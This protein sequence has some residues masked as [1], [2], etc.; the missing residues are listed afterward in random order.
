M[1]RWL[2]IPAALAASLAVHA[3]GLSLGVTPDAVQ[4]EGGANVAEVRIGSAFRD[5]VQGT[6]NAASTPVAPSPT[7]QPTTSVR[8]HHPVTPSARPVTAVASAP[9]THQPRSD[10]AT[11]TAAMTVTTPT[12]PV[13][14]AIDP[15]HST[16]IA[17]SQSHATPSPAVTAAQPPVAETIVASEPQATTPLI[18]ARPPSKPAVPEDF[19]PT[20]PRVQAARGNAD[21]DRRAGSARGQEQA[22]APAAPAAQARAQATSSGAAAAANYA[23]QVMARLARQRVPRLSERGRATVG[24]SI[25]SSGGLGSVSLIAS[26]GS[27]VVDR[28]ALGFVRSAAPFPRPPAGAQTRFSVPFGVSR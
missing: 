18:S 28:A 27:S 19:R 17:P 15:Q 14:P 9:A 13:T 23:G 25:T 5:T 4:V 11:S 16:S 6:P 8:P 26:S 7:P 10:T 20:P 3:A 1:K 21:A 24:F 22:R 12:A 2:G